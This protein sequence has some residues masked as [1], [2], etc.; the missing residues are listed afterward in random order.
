MCQTRRQGIERQGSVP[1]R[2]GI[3]PG[4]QCVVFA[5]WRG[6]V[7]D[8]AVVL[9]LGG[10]IFGSCAAR[11]AT[12]GVDGGFLYSYADDGSG[13]HGAS[14]LADTALSD[15]Q[16]VANGGT[17]ISETYAFTDA[18]FRIDV[19]QTRSGNAHAYAQSFGNVYFTV[20]SDQTLVYSLTGQYAAADVN[21]MPG[22]IY[23]FTWLDDLTTGERLF[24]TKQI[25]VNTPNE[26]FIPGQMGGDSYDYRMG[27]MTGD[28]AAGDEYVW[29]YDLLIATDAATSSNGSSATG[30]LT[31]AFSDKEAEPHVVV[32]PLPRAVGSGLSVL[33]GAFLCV[34]RRARRRRAFA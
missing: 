19:T 3:S 12:V 20:L 11:A 32:V 13:A 33:G 23:L 7:R 29:H 34:A 31:L 9:M 8:A 24:D 16:N 14:T 21:A 6:I 22:E 17:S 4:C 25:S 28:L 1:M 18:A 15:T 26:V 27:N 5:G 10:F 2:V 30:Y